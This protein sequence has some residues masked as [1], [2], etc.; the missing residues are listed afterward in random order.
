[1]IKACIKEMKHVAA[2]GQ[3][4][5]PSQIARSAELFATIKQM[6]VA[7]NESTARARLERAHNERERNERGRKASAAA[8]SSGTAAAMKERL[9]KKALARKAER[10]LA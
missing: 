4:G 7:L 2:T 8:A 10:S 6:A 3:K 5:T 9:R 1:M